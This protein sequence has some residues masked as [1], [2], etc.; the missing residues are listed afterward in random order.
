M[1]RLRFKDSFDYTSTCSNQID[2]ANICIPPLILQPFVENAIWHG[3]MHKETKGKLE[4]DITLENEF[5]CCTIS[6]N[7]IG[8]SIAA[9]IK[10]SSAEKTKPMGL[11][12]T[13]SR[14]DIINEKTEEQQY[15]EIHDLTDDTGKP[16]GTRVVVKIKC[17][18]LS[19]VY[20]YN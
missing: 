11:N 18:Q 15:F 19:G 20:N 17:R 2:A 10:S 6:D 16:G 5:L 3:L 1:E 4:I 7:G 8:R 13:K 12:I 14:I 9:I